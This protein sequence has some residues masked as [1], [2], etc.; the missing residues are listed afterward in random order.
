MC[1]SLGNAL[2][3]L[4]GGSYGSTL[5]KRDKRLPQFLAGA[6]TTLGCIP[7]WFLMNSVT[8]SAPFWWVGLIAFT[9]GFGSGPTGPI[10]KAT[11]TNVTHPRTR[12]QAFALF[13]LFDDLGKGLGPYFV[14]LL[15]VRMGG[16]LK[17]FN[18]ALFGWVIC[19]VANLLIFF[20][21]SQDE[22]KVQAEV[23]SE[24]MI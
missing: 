20:T 24:L 1:F 3:L 16:R 11:V 10:I 9:S 18:V 12:G 4:L 8:S 7:L 14:S 19:G 2:G 23:R 22:A 15:I 13:T 5:Y 6:M 21:V 17:A